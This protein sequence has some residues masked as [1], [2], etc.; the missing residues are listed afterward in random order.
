MRQ[1]LSTAVQSL[2]R[3]VGVA[4][5]R[6]DLPGD[7]LQ[8]PIV[9]RDLPWQCPPLVTDMMFERMPLQTFLDFPIRAAS[10]EALYSWWARTLETM[11]YSPS[12]LV[13]RGALVGSG[14]VFV[15]SRLG[16][17]A[18]RFS[19]PANC[20]EPL[21]RMSGIVFSLEA[22]HAAHLALPGAVLIKSDDSYYVEVGGLVI[23][24]REGRPAAGPDW[25]VTAEG[26]VPELLTMPRGE[27]MHECHF[28]SLAKARSLL[29]EH[30]SRF[31][32]F[33]TLD[34]VLQA[35]RYMTWGS[36]APNV[37][38]QM[39]IARQ[40]RP[41]AEEHI[42]K[43]QRSLELLDD[44]AV[45]DR[46][47]LVQMHGTLVPDIIS[48]TAFRNIFHHGPPFPY[49][50]RPEKMLRIKQELEERI[51]KLERGK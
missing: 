5:Q 35:L 43:L 6:A 7:A 37:L 34:T 13:D 20:P 42:R 45:S 19:I 4:F 15:G 24:V 36:I 23:G 10:A 47:K 14:S 40:M 51:S 50:A 11:Y 44:P 32:E 41:R 38:Q 31:P 1:G 33:A 26:F 22:A 46:A 9:Y 25:E 29:H 30:P 8:T 39:T 48:P 49:V 27:R 3:L 16:A 18:L 17:R 21:D 2:V 12:R 28:D